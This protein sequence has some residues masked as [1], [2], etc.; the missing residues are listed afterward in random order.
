MPQNPA[1]ACQT[2]RVY[3]RKSGGLPER[4]SPRGKSAG[5]L[6]DGIA[7]IV[8]FGE[9]PIEA[10]KLGQGIGEAVPVCF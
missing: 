6:G 8:D 10:M 5:G 3:A 9:T 2:A 4:K 1:N 7:E